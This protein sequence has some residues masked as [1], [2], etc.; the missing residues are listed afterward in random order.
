[1]NRRACPGCAERYPFE[2]H[3]RRHVAVAYHRLPSGDAFACEAVPTITAV[4][5]EKVTVGQPTK[6]SVYI[7]IDDFVR[8]IGAVLQPAAARA[9]ARAL[10]AAA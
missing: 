1:M 7:E 10:E 6:G 9:L 8:P 5:G 3:R 2:M 4:H